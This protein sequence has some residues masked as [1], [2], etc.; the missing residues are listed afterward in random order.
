MIKVIGKIPREFGV[1]CS[2]GVDSMAILDFLLKGGHN[3]HVLYFNHNT[4][5][6][7]IAED[8]VTKYCQDNNLKLTISRTDL[9]PKSNKEKI[10]SDLRYEFFSK[11]D[12]PII[13][14]H[15]LDD[16]VETYLFSCL[17]GF[18][19]VIPYSKGNVIRPFL[20][21]EK[22]V[23]YKWC[24]D[25]NVPFV[26]DE[27]NFSVDYSRNRIRHNIVP[28]ALLVNPGLKTVVKKMINSLQD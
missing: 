7:Q 17:R 9:S 25:K 15:H 20:H 26:E 4:D 23:F 10:W 27:S 11:F 8:F 12:F 3:P 16:C 22:S 14:C 19:S 5:H 21:N 2:G 13:T 1:A 28:E 6:G 18:Q 24:L